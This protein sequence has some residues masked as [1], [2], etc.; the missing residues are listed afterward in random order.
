MGFP[1]MP[2]LNKAGIRTVTSFQWKDL[3]NFYLR[4]MVVFMII[5]VG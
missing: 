3:V 1:M 2:C 5:T 4:A